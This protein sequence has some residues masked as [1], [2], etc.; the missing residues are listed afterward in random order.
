MPANVRQLV[1][2]NA[3]QLPG[4][5]PREAAHRHEN[6]RAANTRSA[7]APRRS[8][9]PAAP[10]AAPP[11]TLRTGRRAGPA[12]LGRRRADAAPAQTPDADPSCHSA[13]IKEA[14]PRSQHGASQAGGADCQDQRPIAR[15][16]R[17]AA[18]R[19]CLH[20][21]AGRSRLP[22]RSQRRHAP[23]PRSPASRRTPRGMANSTAH[24][25]AYRRRAEFARQNHS[26]QQQRQ[27][28]AFPNEMQP[29][30]SPAPRQ[31]ACRPGFQYAHGVPFSYSSRNRRNSASS[32]REAR[33]AERAPSMRL[34]AEPPNARCSKSPASCRWV[35]SRGWLA[36]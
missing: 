3:F 31:T 14:T 9:I 34:F 27:D 7:L 32:S 20:C 29:A 25:A 19:P 28:D 6:R 22:A 33:R 12:T 17:L 16:G 15:S 1:D 23:P 4:G 8:T 2:Q 35:H 10:P 13:P 21:S 11:A 30:P 24:P 5:K 18:R 36:A 26:S